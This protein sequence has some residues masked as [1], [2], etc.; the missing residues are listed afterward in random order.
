LFIY[1]YN[2]DSK[3]KDSETKYNNT[4]YIEEKKEQQMRFVQ[5]EMK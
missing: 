2:Y 3:H 5:N 4:I 1:I